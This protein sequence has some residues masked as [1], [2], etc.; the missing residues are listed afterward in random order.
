[1]LGP[2]LSSN[3]VNGWSSACTPARAGLMTS[4]LPSCMP[5]GD[6]PSAAERLA[7]ETLIAAAVDTTGVAF[8]NSAADGTD[9][10]AD[11]RFADLLG[12]GSSDVGQ[13][14]E[15]WLSRIDPGH[16]DLV[17]SQARQLQSGDLERATAEVPV[18]TPGPGLDLAPA[19]DATRRARAWG[20]AP[21]RRAAGHH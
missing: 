5:S 3:S 7:L 8:A 1:M 14:P 9:V 15:A 17:A 2:R 12:L 13:M 20:P 21:D 11:V 6:R 4:G 19:H 10:M 16:R 18:C